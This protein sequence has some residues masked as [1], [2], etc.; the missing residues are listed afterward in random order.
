MTAA[1]GRARGFTLIEL[2]TALLILS[3]LGLMSYRGLG[4]VLDARA[5]IDTESAKW[6]SLSVF[7]AR[8]ERDIR[9]AAPRTARTAEGSAPAWRGQPATA[10]GP[11]LEFSRFASDDTLDD[12]RR[13]G[14]GR[15]ARGEVE[16]WLWPGLDATPE[17]APVRH[18]VLEGVSV[19]ELQYLD[20]RR[21]WVTSWPAANASAALPRA[22][23]LRLVLATGED[24]SR[25]FLLQP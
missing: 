18:V 23:R 8:F 6:R 10:A 15:N 14:Y 13:V 17:S 9:L 25:V 12:A 24:I 2:L 19:F 11:G 16:L 22:L 5:S 7:F 1:P 3:L 20:A 4:A 21:S